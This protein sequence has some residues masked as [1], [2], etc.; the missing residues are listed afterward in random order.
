MSLNENVRK[1]RLLKGLS[2]ENM[3]EHL[4][5]S[6]SQYNRM[7]TGMQ[8]ITEERLVKLAELLNL[9]VE[10]LKEFDKIPFLVNNVDNQHGGNNGFNVSY[11]LSVQEKEQYEA[12]IKYL[13]EEIQ[14]L[15][16]LLEKQKLE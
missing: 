4:G 2:Q 5:L 1:I 9:E 15:R 13:E 6:Q 8:T 7:E 14:F 10:V 12:R 3:A 11:A 16:R